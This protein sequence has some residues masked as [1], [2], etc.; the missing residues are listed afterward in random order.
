M[1]L[2]SKTVRGSLDPTGFSHVQVN[3]FDVQSTERIVAGARRLARLWKELTPEDPS[4]RNRICIKIPSS[5]AGLRA[6]EILQRDFDIQTLATT[7]FS[8]AQAVVAGHARCRYVA[9]YMHGLKD[10]MS[11]K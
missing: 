2:L 5:W 11:A 8:V 1:I 4:I 6:C 3:P 7:L 9:P 10:V